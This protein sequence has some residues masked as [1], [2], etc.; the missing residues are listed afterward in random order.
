MSVGHYLSGINNGIPDGCN[1][2]APGNFHHKGEDYVKPNS[3]WL[4]QLNTFESGVNTPFGCA[5]SGSDP[6]AA[7]R[8]NYRGY[9]DCYDD[10]TLG[11]GQPGCGT[12]AE[13][14]GPY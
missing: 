10:Y 13:I 1:A 3:Q 8:D 6:A 14:H 4:S 7:A 2:A 12:L 9:Q 5:G 11:W